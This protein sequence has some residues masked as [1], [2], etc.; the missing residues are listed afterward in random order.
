M[1]KLRDKCQFAD[2][3]YWLHLD[4]LRCVLRQLTTVGGDGLVHLVEDV[5]PALAGLFEGFAHQLSGDAVAS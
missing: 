1:L 3:L 2:V 4:D 5:H